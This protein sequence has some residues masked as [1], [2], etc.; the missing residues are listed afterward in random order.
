MN[1]LSLKIRNDEYFFF[2]ADPRPLA[3]KTKIKT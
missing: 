3:K 1:I 2:Y